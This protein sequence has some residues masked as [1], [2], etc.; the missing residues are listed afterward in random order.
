[1]NIPQAERPYPLEGYG[2]P[3]TLDGLLTWEHVIGRLQEARNY[4]VCTTH[5]N[6]TPHARPVWGVVVDDLLYVGGG[7]TRWARNL[8]A[9]SKVG[10]HLEDGDNGLV[11]EG[12][13]TYITEDKA[14]IAKTDAAYLEKYNIPHGPVWQITPH[15]VIAWY[16][17]L[18]SMTRWRFK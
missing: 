6:G 9:N 8:K 16:D 14:L 1:M 17:G 11:I 12:I 2:I 13:A 3:E 15:K 7:D 5:P 4:W 10:I 18:N